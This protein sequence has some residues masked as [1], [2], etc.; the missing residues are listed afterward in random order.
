MWSKHSYEIV[1]RLVD[2][3]YIFMFSSGLSVAGQW[4]V[5]FCREVMEIVCSVAGA[6]IDGL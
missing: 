1:F 3:N 6:D 2:I 5:Q 4:S